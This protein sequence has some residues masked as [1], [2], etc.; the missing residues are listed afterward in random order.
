MSYQR[1]LQAIFDDI[2]DCAAQIE[3]D[4]DAFFRRFP[5]L[6]PMISIGDGRIIYVSQKSVIA[7]REIARTYRENSSERQR[8][9]SQNEMAELVSGGIGSI[10]GASFSAGA[11]D[12]LIPTDPESFWVA[13]REQLTRDIANL[14]HELTHLFG[15]WVLQGDSIP[16]VEI[17]PVRLSLRSQWVHD[18]VA[19]RILTTMQISRL[20][21]YWEH[22][23]LF[24]IDSAEGTDDRT[25]RE[26]IDTIGPCPWICAVRVFDHTPEKSRQKALLAA[27][28]AFAAISLTW[29]TPSEQ[30]KETGLI[31]DKGPWRT[32]HT[33]MF[34]NGRLIGTSCESVLRSGRFLPVR[35]DTAFVASTRH[36]TVGAALDTFLSTNP[37]GTKRL[38]EQALCHSLI[39]FGEACNEPLD[40]MAIVKFVAALDT[41]AKGRGEVGICDL[42]QRHFPLPNMD[43]AFLNTSAK[44]LV[45][46]IYRTGRSQIVHGVHSGLVDGLDQ[47][48]MRAE[49]LATIVL[50]ACISWLD[51]YEGPDDVSA[52]AS[53][54]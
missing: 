20:S 25:T 52:F 14:N 22:G 13:L 21:Y 30:A 24:N 41:L 27:R 1:H 7:V 31:Y 49:L 26:I 5:L 9:L 35:D 15:A 16:F 6:P 48:R 42:I 37:T 38:L 28:I 51:T 3:A 29:D 4:R 34:E 23:S 11:T 17:G 18:A 39:W 2:R 12:F 46:K 10:I 50:R 33:T 53:S 32:R 47:L 36:K 54:V 40:F 45:E 43:A 44:K 19:A 8:A